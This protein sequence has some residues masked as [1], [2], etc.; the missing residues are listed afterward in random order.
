MGADRE[1]T[2]TA[3]LNKKVSSRCVSPVIFADAPGEQHSAGYSRDHRINQAV[4]ALAP[5][6]LGG[7]REVSA[8]YLLSF[9]L[10]AAVQVIAAVI[11]VVGA[12]RTSASVGNS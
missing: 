1:Q 2:H 9:G 10:A 6:I 12:R 4:F 5:A 7:L 11:V 8:D 3:A